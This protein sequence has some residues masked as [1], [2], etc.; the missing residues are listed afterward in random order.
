MNTHALNEQQVALI[1][2][3]ERAGR[4]LSHLEPVAA[5]L[6]EFP[7]SEA[8]ELLQHFMDCENHHSLGLWLNVCAMAEIKLDLLLLF[9]CIE[10][11]E[12]AED[13]VTCLA[14][15]N[16][17]A[18]NTTIAA[19]QQE[20]FN[21]TERL[22]LFTFGT[23]LAL[24]YDVDREP[25]RRL[26]L[27]EKIE[28]GFFPEASSLIAT[29]YQAVE[30]K[31]AGESDNENRHNFRRLDANIRDILPQEHPPRVLASGRSV[32]HSEKKLS[33]NDPCHCGSG[34]K[35]KTCCLR[36]DFESQN[37]YVSDGVSGTSTENTTDIATMCGYQIRKLDPDCI[38]ISQA[39]LAV[40][41]LS[42]LGLR[43]RAFEILVRYMGTDQTEE[44]S[45][46]P[47]N[48]EDLIF[49]CFEACDL[50]MAERIVDYM[51]ANKLN[52]LIPPT[53]FRLELLRRSEHYELLEQQCVKSLGIEQ[54]DNNVPDSYAFK[55]A[56]RDLAHDL[57]PRYPGLSIALARA[58]VA[59]NPENSAENDLLVE[60]IEINRINL[61]YKPWGDPA[62]ELLRM[63]E[64]EEHEEANYFEQ[65]KQIDKLTEQTKKA[66]AEIRAKNRTLHELEAQLAREHKQ[67]EMK[68]MR[69]EH[70][71]APT[72]HPPELQQQEELD[73]LRRKVGN[74]KSEISAQQEQRSQLRRQLERERYRSGRKQQQ[75]SDADLS[76]PEAEQGMDIPAT[77]S[78]IVF[79]QYSDSFLQ[80]CDR[81]PRSIVVKAMQMLTSFAIQK[82]SIYQHTRKLECMKDHYRMRVGIHHR[83]LVYWKSGEKL[84]AQ[85]LI[86]RK[87]L[88]SWIKQHV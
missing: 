78:H 12:Y 79:P 9:D 21:T 34:K 15:H 28:L 24:K 47:G 65:D 82:H 19:L 46:A 51:Q 61:G 11:I 1:Q 35:Y 25:F 76:A 67:R 57:A 52:F 83:L 85:A 84:I 10:R 66:Q 63:M 88:E 13:L 42:A 2:R 33:R 3:L 40:R 59:S 49:D 71:A 32:R 38:P 56:F 30:D 39:V 44:D 62:A 31:D 41:E 26:L 50:E 87:E 68:A 81:L 27:L 75:A 74:L 7:A 80:Q 48:L 53:I 6:H 36:R 73:R 14:A 4:C 77:S 54:D 22:L 72:S 23:E 70:A 64:D 60:T 58:A 45:L 69:E 86:H 37:E 43:E 18:Y 16:E 8:N 17:A 20:R 5:E 55:Q 29:M